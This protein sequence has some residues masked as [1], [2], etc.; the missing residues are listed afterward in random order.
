MLHNTKGVGWV[1]KIK[2]TVLKVVRD[3]ND[4]KVIITDM[5]CHEG[6]VTENYYRGLDTQWLVQELGWIGDK[7]VR[8]ITTPL[9]GLASF[10]AH[11]VGFL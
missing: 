8:R 1:F 3:Q 10:K 7:Q 4:N 2:C 6:H 9:L 5:K 11:H